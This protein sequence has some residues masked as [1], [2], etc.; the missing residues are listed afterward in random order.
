MK[1]TEK[2]TPFQLKLANNKR[3][4]VSFRDDQ[5]SMVWPGVSCK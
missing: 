1:Q 4:R 3:K 5:G 2:S